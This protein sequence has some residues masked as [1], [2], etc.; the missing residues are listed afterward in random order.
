[1]LGLFKKFNLLV[2]LIILLSGFILWF[3]NLIFNTREILPLNE[4]LM[5]LSF[6]MIKIF[7]NNIVF[8]QIVAFF[9]IVF[10]GIYI[11]VL[12]KKFIFLDSQTYL[13]VL[14]FFF[15]AS[16]FKNIVFFHPVIVSNLF[17][18]FAFNKVFDTYKKDLT[19]SD[20]FEASFL[21][22]VGSMFYF[23]FI[24]FIIS[25]W[26]GLMILRT[27]NFREWIVTILGLLSPY[28]IVFAYLFLID[29]HIIYIKAISEVFS[30]PIGQFR[31]SISFYIVYSFVV[32]LI[33]ISL[34][35]LFSG[36]NI[37]KI[38]T[39]KFFLVLSWCLPIVIVLSIFKPYIFEELFFFLSFPISLL[40][41]DFFIKIKYKWV[42]EILFL[43]FFILIFINQFV[44]L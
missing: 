35:R 37:K 25:V 33:I 10:Q 7:H 4:K 11:I 42:S 28:I 13:P 27:F 41:A 38:K 22:S 9:L 24:F 8:A 5:P 44:N 2:L 14:I 19:Y 31:L 3:N 16:I 15:I 32:L 39:R 6:G 12:N 20:F 17:L 34:I 21:I 29:K 18:L 26:I 1:M 30:L 23:Y 43:L 40:I 36:Y